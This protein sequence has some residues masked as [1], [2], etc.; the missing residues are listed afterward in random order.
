[1]GSG[2]FQYIF[3]FKMIKSILSI[4]FI[5]TIV[6][7]LICSFYLVAQAPERGP[8]ALEGVTEAKVI[9]QIP[10]F[11]QY[12]DVKVKKKAFFDFFRPMVKEENQ[13]LRNEHLRI[14]ALFDD[15][16]D[17]GK[18]SASDQKWLEDMAVYYRVSPFDLTDKEDQGLLLR[19]VDIIPESL[20]L[21]QAANESAWGTSRFAKTANN[22]FGQW[23]FTQGCGIVPRQRKPGD[24]QE[25]QKFATLNDGVRSYMHHL[26]SHPFYVKLRD[27]REAA[28]K[29]GKAPSGY[30]M[31]IGLEKYSAKGL[32]YVK[33]VRSM[34]SFN[35]LEAQR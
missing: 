4:R 29:A 28:R 14:V 20:F 26:N 6:A 5:Y 19:R 10:D 23:C 35:K 13:I 9:S 1:M 15:L 32:A 11:T 8:A 2:D 3:N 17:S 16:E 12:K 31:A 33:E 7:L 18:I 30:A 24:I 22:I 34:I 21:A 27:A 25:V